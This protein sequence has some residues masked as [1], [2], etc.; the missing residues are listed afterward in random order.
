MLT[1]HEIK[2]VMPTLTDEQKLVFVRR[3][4]AQMVVDGIATGELEDH[5]DGEIHI[6]LP[7]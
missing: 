4:I 5:G 7:Q 1:E 3:N 6:P 2:H